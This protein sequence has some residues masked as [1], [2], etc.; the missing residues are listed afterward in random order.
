[1][2]LGVPQVGGAEIRAAKLGT[3]QVRAEKLNAAQL[4]FGQV[5]AYEHGLRHVCIAQVGA[6]KIG[7]AQIGAAEFR[8]AKIGQREARAAQVGMREDYA[9]ELR[10]GKIGVAQVGAD[11]AFAGLEKFEMRPE[12]LL[13]RFSFMHDRARMTQCFTLSSGS[14]LY[15]PPNRPMTAPILLKIANS[16]CTHPHCATLEETMLPAGRHRVSR[17]ALLGLFP[18]LVCLFCFGTNLRATQDGQGESIESVSEVV[19]T[20]ASGQVT[21]LSARDGIVVAA[22]GNQFEPD[23]LPPLIV[24]LGDRD[25]AVVLGAADWIKPPPDKRTL[26]RLDRQLPQMIHGFT[27]NAPRL[28]T[29]PSVSNLERVGLAVLGPLR[30]VARNLHAHIDFPQGVPFAEVVLVHQ[31]MGGGKPTVWALSYWIRQRFLQEN[32]WDTQVERPRSIQLFPTK[33]NR[34]GLVDVR[35]PPDDQSEGLLDW[36]AKPTGRLA[37]D[38]ETDPKLAKAQKDIAAGKNRKVHL[39]EMV[40]LVKATLEAMTPAAKAKAMVEIEPGHGFSWVIQPPVETK[41]KRQP[42]APTLNPT[43]H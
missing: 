18:L 43:P 15:S 37:Q 22:I 28:R 42:G 29:G 34:T 21:I 2:H 10:A 17:P 26:L 40:P 36:L 8:A 27:G 14:A 19:V 30:K 31:P 9:S 32:F 41:P 20:L 3:A 6:T 4:R 24:P 16:D 1:M 5:G 39:A 7:I 33:E 13:E 23:D 25:L 12:N 11:S 38:I 35:Y